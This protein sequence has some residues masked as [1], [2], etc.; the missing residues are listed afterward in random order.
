MSQCT[1]ISIASLPNDLATLAYL[2]RLHKQR[3][4]GNV[5]VELNL[6]MMRPLKMAYLPLYEVEYLFVRRHDSIV[7]FLLLVSR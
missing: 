2:R 4:V 7:L 6:L 1:A 3:K 5:N